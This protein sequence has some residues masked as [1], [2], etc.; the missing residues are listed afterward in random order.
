MNNFMHGFFYPFRCVK[1]FFRYPG[2]ILYSIVPMMINLVIYGTIFFYAYNWLIGS[3]SD[4]VEKNLPDNLL[5]DF[6]N[7]FLKLFSFLLVLLICYFG[8]VIFGGI[9]SAPFNEKMSKL[10][11][12]KEFGIVTE[13]KMSFFDETYFS[14]KE[15]LK[16]I[17]FYVSIMI[18]L[19]LINFIPMI[20]NTISFVFGGLFSFF[21]NALDYMDYPMTRS[22]TVFSEKLRIISSKKT[23][24]MG[25]GM[26]AFLLTF[27][28]VI[29]V[30]INPLLVVSGT[31]FFYKNKFNLS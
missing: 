15:E 29:N 8:F 24:A 2:L 4:A 20:G 30:L 25:F 12:E 11:E 23:L 16:K 3:S 27:I 1:L 28:P 26:I 18:P 5:V 10:I 14:I 21:Y 9:V 17:L 31:S 19:F 13:S 22:M 6:L 7:F